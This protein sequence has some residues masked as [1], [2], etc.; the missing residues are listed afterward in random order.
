M[1]AEP[2][3]LKQQA[4]QYTRIFSP[5][6]AQQILTMMEAVVSTEGTARRAKI[7][8]YRVAG[9]TGTV[10]KITEQGYSHEHHLGLFVGIAPASNPRFVAAV[11]IDDP[12]QGGYYGGVVA[13]PVFANVMKQALRLYAVA[14]DKETDDIVRVTY[15]VASN[16]ISAD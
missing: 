4:S 8:G 16:D 11:L 5:Q 9:K 14:P 1:A 7:S 6:V 3:I 15:S 2:S 13:A 10:Q 12:Q